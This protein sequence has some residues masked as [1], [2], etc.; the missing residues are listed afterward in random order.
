M[1]PARVVHELKVN[2]YPLDEIIEFCRLNHAHDAV[3]YICE[4]QGNFEEA[5]SI[6]SSLFIDECWRTFARITKG[7]HHPSEALNP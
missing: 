6:Y 7:K 4:R 3:A 1:E 5:I 2:F